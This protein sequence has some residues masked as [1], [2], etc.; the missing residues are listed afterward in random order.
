[1]VFA[2]KVSLGFVLGAMIV[3]FF[4]TVSTQLTAALLVSA[5]EWVICKRN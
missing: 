3:G 5:K 2:P 1:M 4:L